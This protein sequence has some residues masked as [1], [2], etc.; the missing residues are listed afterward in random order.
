[1]KVV[2][3]SLIL[4]LCGPAFGQAAGIAKAW[5]DKDSDIYGHRIMGSIAEHLR[6]NA[7]LTDGTVVTLD[8]AAGGNPTHV[9]EDMAPRLADMDGDGTNELVVVETD[10]AAGA[11]LAIYGLGDGGLKKLAETPHIGSPFR[12]LAPVGVGDFNGDGRMDVAYVDRPHLAKLLRV[13]SFDG[14]NLTEIARAS[15][16]TNHRIGDEVIAGGVRTC[17]GQDQMVLLTG[18]WKRI[19]VARFDGG[20]LKLDVQ[21]SYTPAALSSVLKD[22]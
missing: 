12:W 11:A 17:G 15:G 13:W 8:L 3:A 2:L 19:V 4:M 16:L 9:F 20:E 5:Y 22:C 21:R 6:L 10:V 7:E 18:N 14:D 1:M